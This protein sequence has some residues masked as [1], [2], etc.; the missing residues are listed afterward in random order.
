MLNRRVATRHDIGCSL[1][2][3]APLRW[4]ERALSKCCFNGESV[5]LWARRVKGCEVGSR[6]YSLFKVCVSTI[7]ELAATSGSSVPHFALRLQ[8]YN[9]TCIAIGAPEEVT[10]W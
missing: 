4:M 8:N 9:E 1:G 3:F 10:R 2:I 7:S 6:R 5:I